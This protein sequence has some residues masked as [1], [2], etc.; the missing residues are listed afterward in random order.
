MKNTKRILSVTVQRMID[1]SPDTSWLGEYSN[2]PDTEYAIDRAHSLVCIENQAEVKAKLE[3]ISGHI[4]D[5]YNDVCM[6][7]N[8]TSWEYLQDARA[9]MEDLLACDCSRSGR[10]D[11]HEYRYFNGPV[12]SYKGETPE[13]IRKYV[14][15][16]YERMES[17]NR[18]DWCFIGVRA[19]AEITVSIPPVTTDGFPHDSYQV[20]H[21]TSGGLWGIESDSEDSYIAEVE[22]EQ[23]AELKTQLRALGFSAR[24]VAKAFQDVEHETE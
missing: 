22:Q 12:D 20:Q 8:D 10:I 18:G 6:D 23:L 14:L 5:M 24:A 4:D 13:D 17:L 7:E 16:D 1:D 15:Q 21:I 2:R 3:R 19:D 9:T 11:S